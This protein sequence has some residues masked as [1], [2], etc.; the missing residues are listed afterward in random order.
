MLDGHGGVLRRRALHHHEHDEQP[1]DS[2]APA[3]WTSWARWPCMPWPRP[4]ASPAPWSTGTT[5]TATTPTRA[6]SSTAAT[7]PRTSSRARPTMDYQEIIAGTVGKENTYGTMVG[8]IKAAP[9]TYLRVSTDDAA[10]KIR[11]YVGEGELTDDPL[12]TFGGYGVVK[13]PES[14][15]AAA[16]HLRERFRASRRRQ[17]DADRRGGQGSP[18]QISRLGGLSPRMSALHITSG[19]PS[20]RPCWRPGLHGPEGSARRADC[21]HPVPLDAAR[22]CCASLQP[23]ICGSDLHTFKDA[24]IGDTQ[25]STPMILGH[26][27]VAVVEAVG[28][29]CPGRGLPTACSR[30]TGGG[31]S[32]PALPPLRYVRAGKSESL[33]QSPLLQQL[34]HDGSL[35]EWMHMPAHSCFPVPRRD[36][37]RGARPAGAAGSGHSCRGPGPHPR[38]QQCGDPRRRSHRTAHSAGRPAG[39]APATVYITDRFD[40]AAETGRSSWA[41]GPINLGDGRSRA[42]AGRRRPENGAW[43][44]SSRPPGVKHRGPGGGN[45]SP[46]RPGVL[47]GIPSVDRPEHE[48]FVGTPQGAD[49]RLCRRMKHVI[50]GP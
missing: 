19:K 14:A 44:S 29:E 11:A 31:R 4:A 21:P 1:A 13:I 15:K 40:H 18:G 43:M 5:T 28:P 8:R 49:H 23:A 25:V 2:A 12:Q 36:R 32:G 17:P 34:S 30:D 35:C 50:L 27:F 20:A 6:S 3:K 42:G 10:G 39:R 26:E 46:G 22:P 9:F 16:L 38:G 24:R 33:P 47:V 37:R 7:C 48:G 41:A 45:G